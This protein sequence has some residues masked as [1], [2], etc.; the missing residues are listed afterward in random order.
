MFIWIS[1]PKHNTCNGDVSGKVN[2]V[3]SNTIKLSLFSF[4][5]ESFLHQNSDACL[6]YK[7]LEQASCTR[8]L[9][10]CRWSD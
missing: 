2:V 5:F 8:F 7:K 9:T 3:L 10:M 1:I 4:G 6:L